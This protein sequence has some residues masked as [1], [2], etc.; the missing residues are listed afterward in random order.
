[1]LAPRKRINV[2]TL[3]HVTSPVHLDNDV[4][5]FMSA[6]D[7]REEDFP[8]EPRL[9][10]PLWIEVQACLVRLRC[11]SNLGHWLAGRMDDLASECRFL[12]ALTPDEFDARA[13]ILAGLLTAHD[14]ASKGGA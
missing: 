4:E 9:S 11:D 2:L 6:E 3:P 12:E 13:E 14:A 1:M 7:C 5:P 8:G 10:M